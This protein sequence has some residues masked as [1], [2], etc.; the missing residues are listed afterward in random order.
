MRREEGIH[1]GFEIRSPPLRQRIADLPFIVDSLAGELASD[2]GETLVEPELEAF[3]FVIFGLEVIAWSRE[4]ERE[5][6]GER[7]ANGAIIFP[8]GKGGPRQDLWLN[9]RTV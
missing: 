4:R 3:D 7:S 9:S 2:G 1:E 6:K 5:R 8:G